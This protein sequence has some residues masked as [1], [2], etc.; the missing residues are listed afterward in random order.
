MPADTA[1]AVLAHLESKGV[2]PRGIFAERSVAASF[3]AARGA[4]GGTVTTNMELG[5]FQGT[6]V[7][8]PKSARG[9][10]RLA[11][12]ADLDRTVV[13]EEAF[14]RETGIDVVPDDFRAWVEREISAGSIYV[15]ELDGDIVSKVTK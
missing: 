15:W 4:R 14:A 11:T 9:K 8:A 13:L 7:I 10:L 2:R 6:D 3:G 1:A 12:A 5:R